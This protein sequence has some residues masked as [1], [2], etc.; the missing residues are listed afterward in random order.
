[1]DLIVQ[2][3]CPSLG[4][5]IGRTAVTDELWKWDA[6]A[7]A[8]GIRTRSISS[9]E[10]VAACAGRMRAVNPGLNAVTCDLTEQA[11]SAAD[12]ADAA[13][14]RGDA[15][16]P[17]HGVPV[18]IKE[19]V[20][21]QGCAT[22]NGV[23]AYKDVIATSDH[24]VV[25]NWKKAGAVIIGRTNTPA[26]SMRLDTVND[27]RGRTYSPWSRTHTPGGSSGGASSSVAAGITP[28]A[29]GNDIAGSV[30]YPAYCTGLAGLRPSFGRVPAYNPSG[31]SERPISAQ[32]MSVQ[33]PLARSVRDVR[34]GLH[35]MAAADV[36]DPW[37]VPAPL[38]GPPAKSPV[39]VAL[40]ADAADLAG[41]SPS[42]PVAAALAQAAKA[43]SD[44]GYEVV[45]TRT[46]GFTAAFD[47][48]FRMHIPEFRRF[49]QADFERDGDDG[50]RV[51]MRLMQDNVPDIGPDDH[52]RALADR[53]RLIR[54]WYAFL[55]H[56]PLVL[57]PV[58][59]E[60]PYA[61]GFDLES[62]ER[63]MEIWRQSS[64]LMAVP[65]LGL[66]GMA[67][68]TGVVDGLPVGVQIVGQRFREDLC[69][70]AAE[71]IEARVP[72]ITPIDP[73]N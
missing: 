8:E 39:R 53:T 58:C 33:G 13:V 16:G 56:T 69:L 51:A 31:K 36:R 21:Q 48:W 24:P 23:A 46:P 57:A 2:N 41:A 11:L 35:A 66:P 25:A 15:L 72:R 37:W 34:L 17:L 18:T 45:S 62:K 65:V 5:G 47:L 10:A 63:T 73:R 3:A 55:D 52:L 26:F 68:P 60:L 12:R 30:R 50:I 54:D 4:R 70:A 43:L 40:V 61:Q 6:V 64:T 49:Q 28:L 1:M 7:L 27:Y 44:A 32:L 71:A 20:D 14:A 19:N 38:E 42:P 59:T 9:R 67:M 22:V 29:H